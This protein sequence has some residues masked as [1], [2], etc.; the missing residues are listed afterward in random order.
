[1]RKKEGRRQRSVKC[2][3]PEH[4]RFGSAGEESVFSFKRDGCY[5]GVWSRRFTFEDN[6]STYGMTDSRLESMERGR[7]RALDQSRKIKLFCI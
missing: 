7:Q 2:E 5:W 6:C 1:M 4:V 3:R